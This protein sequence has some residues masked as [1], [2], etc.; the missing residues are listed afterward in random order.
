MS[1]TLIVI[2]VIITIALIIF[3]LVVSY[4][5]QKKDEK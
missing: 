1:F 5:A 2:C 3:P 4:I